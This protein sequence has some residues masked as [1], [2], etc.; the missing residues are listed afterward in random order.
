MNVKNGNQCPMC[1]TR[2]NVTAVLSDPE[3]V[4]HKEMTPSLLYENAKPQESA[5]I[6]METAAPY[7][8][9]KLAA[10]AVQMVQENQAAGTE[11]VKDEEKA[12]KSG[13]VIEQSSR[14]TCN[15]VLTVL[16]DL[17]VVTRVEVTQ[18]DESHMVKIEARLR[19]EGAKTV[20]D[21]SEL[22]IQTICSDP[23]EALKSTR[24]NIFE[25]AFTE[26]VHP[27][28]GCG[29]DEIQLTCPIRSEPIVEQIVKAVFS[30]TKF[31][32]PMVDI[33][34]KLMNKSFDDQRL[35]NM[36]RAPTL[37]IFTKVLRERTLS[38]C[39]KSS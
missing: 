24:Y 34:W 36:R 30:S 3:R 8:N 18:K 33:V 35:K 11:L 39:R 6:L 15:E 13:Y 29:F 25:H 4:N 10:T 12:M 2:L 23:N 9:S 17:G 27:G 28:R 21:A 31:I 37:T 5:R 1:S 7:W 26:V 22:G 20:A 32:V 16:V 14:D 19:A 38:D